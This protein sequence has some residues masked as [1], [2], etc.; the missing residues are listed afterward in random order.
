MVRLLAAVFLLGG[1]GRL[2]SLAAHGWPDRFQVV[3]TV[4]ELILPPIWFWLADA[5]ERGA[6]Q[7]AQEAS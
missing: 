2:L 7:P 6:R 1:V 4:I 3:L 5:D